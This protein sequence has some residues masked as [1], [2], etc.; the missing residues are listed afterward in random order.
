MLEFYSWI[1]SLCF[2]CAVPPFLIKWSARFE[3]VHILDIG[4]SGWTD[5]VDSSEFVSVHRCF[6]FS[7]CYPLRTVL[8]DSHFFQRTFCDQNPNQYS[9]VT[10]RYLPN[11]ALC[12]QSICSFGESCILCVSVCVFNIMISKQYRKVN[13]DRTE[14]EHIGPSGAF[15][16]YLVHGRLCARHC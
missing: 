1:N 8:T 9:F 3:Y 2:L 5:F 14:I 16:E 13:L 7:S 15:A 12:K 10:L 11:E 4:L 6:N